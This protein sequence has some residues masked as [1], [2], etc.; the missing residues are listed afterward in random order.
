MSYYGRQDSHSKI[1][2]IFTIIYSILFL[3]IWIFILLLY[4]PEGPEFVSINLILDIENV[5]LYLIREFCFK[6]KKN[7]FQQIKRFR[8]PT[9]NIRDDR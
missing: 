5:S 2:L 7:I 9:H 8:T 4:A 1:F 3:S 6:Y